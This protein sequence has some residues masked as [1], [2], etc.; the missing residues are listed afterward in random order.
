MAKIRL[1]KH[2]G[3]VKRKVIR[4]A[5]KRGNDVGAKSS[6]VPTIPVVPVASSSIQAP[7]VPRTSE[8]R[9]TGE[10]VFV[11]LEKAPLELVHVKGRYEL[12]NADDH[13]NM[14]LKHGRDLQNCR[15]DI[16]HQCLMTLL[17]SPLNKA[18]KLFIYI[19]T[20]NNV[21]IEVHPSL[22]IPRTFKRFAGL[23]V[24]LLQRNKIKAA[25]AN[26]TLMKVVSNPV[27]KY[28]PEGGRKVGLSVN[29]RLTD[30]RS[31]VESTPEEATKIPPTFV[32]GAVAHGDPLQDGFGDWVEEQISISNWGLSAANC[33]SKI[34]NEFENRWS[35]L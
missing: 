26:T 34:M 24:E 32:V 3:V 27:T 22:R 20:A 35:V 13:K 5:E 11:V 9:K 23:M 4:K 17:D 30:F 15:P 19:H 14:C 25:G 29:G 10:R 7:R 1:G 21:L 31:Y 8:E 16:T 2:M 6:L 28:L 18:G 33:C 12:M